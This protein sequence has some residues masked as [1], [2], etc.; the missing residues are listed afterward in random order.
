M[1]SETDNDMDFILSVFKLRLLCIL[2]FMPRVTKCISCKD[3]DNLTKFSIR[4]N[5]FKCE[6]CGRQDKSAI[7][8]SES[9]KNAILYTITAPP[10]KVF[11]FSLKDESLKEFELIT[12]IYFNEKLEKEYKLE[13][14][15]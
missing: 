13:D 14:L 4:D 3:E 12:K 1:I 10:K 6:A 7:D 9:T 5:G 8:M 11:S 2:G 15:F